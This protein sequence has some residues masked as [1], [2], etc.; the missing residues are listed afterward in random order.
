VWP[1]KDWIDRKW[2]TM[3]G[4]GLT[5]MKAPGRQPDPAQTA[6][7]VALSSGPAALATLTASSMRCSGCASKVGDCLCYCYGCCVVAAPK[8]FH[9]HRLN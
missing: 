8:N 6:R 4:A 3:Y 2:M 7:L 1:I 5:D 9:S